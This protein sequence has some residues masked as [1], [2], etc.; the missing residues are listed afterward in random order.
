MEL[1]RR[2]AAV[3]NLVGSTGILVFNIVTGLMLV[4]YYLRHLNHATY[5]AWLA[6]GGIIA[7]LG[8]LESGLGTV[9]TQK[10]AT[11]WQ[12]N[13]RKQFAELTGTYLVAVTMVALVFVLCGLSAAWLIPRLIDMTGVSET[14]LRI[15]IILSVVGSAMM[16]AANLIGAI[17]QAWQRTVLPGLVL[18]VALFG[19]VTAIIL[20]LK[21]GWG[22]S[23]LGLGMFCMGVVQLPGLG[24]VVWMHWRRS[25]CPKPR[26]S[27]HTF[28]TLWRDAAP[29]LFSRICGVLGSNLQAPVASAAV[30]SQASAVLVLS[31]RPQSIVPM[32]VDR[33]GSAVFAGMAGLS[34]ANAQEKD[35]TARDLIGVSTVLSGIGLGMAFAFSKPVVALW[36]GPE[37]Y[38]GD[39]LLMLLVA[40]SLATIRKNLYSTLMLSFGQF[41]KASRWLTIESGLRVL[42]LIGLVPLLKLAGIPLADLM[43]SSITAFMLGILLVGPGGLSISVIWRPGLRAFVFAVAIAIVWRWRV[44]CPGSVTYCWRASSGAVRRLVEYARLRARAERL[45]ITSITRQA[46]RVHLRFSEDAGVDAERILD[47]VR[48]TPGASLSPARVLTVPA[49]DG[50]ALLAALIELLPALARQAA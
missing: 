29:L 43:A 3:A 14:S 5:G 45:G 22:I 17:P 26:F 20:A 46:G 11:T 7:M 19:N 8:L 25:H 34:R 27:R 41:S 9:A 44:E 33:V 30:S 40:A 42:L 12:A 36:V 15:G 39:A 13:H 10:L 18:W 28:V 47:L 32:V 35:R 6:S 4:P 31:G 23:A 48:R 16:L 38:G 49:P 37:L 2:F 21:H 50:D 24:A 1:N